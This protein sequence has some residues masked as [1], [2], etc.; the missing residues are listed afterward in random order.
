MNEQKKLREQILEYLI[1]DINGKKFQAN[2]KSQEIITRAINAME[3]VGAETTEWI[4]ANNQIAQVSLL[5]LKTAL[6]QAMIKTSD[7]YLASK[8]GTLT[9]DDLREARRIYEV[10]V[11]S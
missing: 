4:L 2:P 8:Q 3:T 10:S 7:I 11:N 6:A 9:F 1:I 5:E